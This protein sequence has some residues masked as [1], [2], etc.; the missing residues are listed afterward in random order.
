MVEDLPCVEEED[1]NNWHPDLGVTIDDREEKEETAS[2][3]EAL[4]NEAKALDRLREKD[5][6]DEV[7]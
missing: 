2:M 5:S 1:G 4:A 3:E 7:A 6:P